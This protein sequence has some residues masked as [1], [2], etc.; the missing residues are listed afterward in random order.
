M[1]LPLL[2]SAATRTRC[3]Y[4][5]DNATIKGPFGFQRTADMLIPSGGS[6]TGNPAEQRVFRQRL[7]VCITTVKDTCYEGNGAHLGAHLCLRHA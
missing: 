2:C 4:S 3:G 1:D 6:A 7:A 5:G